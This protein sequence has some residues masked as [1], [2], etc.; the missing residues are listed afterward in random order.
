MNT[1]RYIEMLE[2]FLIPTLKWEHKC[3]STIFQQDGAK[4]HTSNASLAVLRKVFHSQLISN[5]T[6]FKWPPCLPDLTC[7]DYFPWGFLKSRVYCN[8]PRTLATL[9]QN[10]S[11][12]IA[13]I[14][15]KMLKDVYSNFV[16]RLENCLE[17]DSQH[18]S[19]I[20]FKQ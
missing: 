1:T 14:P 19:D 15:C 9:K 6:Y 7:C 17:H 12:E 5:R 3:G 11:K 20:V 10:I 16:K 13:K 8:K 18:L 4:A 2:Q